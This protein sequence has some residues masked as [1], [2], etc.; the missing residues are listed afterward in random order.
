MDTLGIYLLVFFSYAGS[1]FSSANNHDQSD[2]EL[3][4]G[5][6]KVRVTFLYSARRMQPSWS[7]SLQLQSPPGWISCLLTKALDPMLWQ[8]QRRDTFPTLCHLIQSFQKTQRLFTLP[9]S[10]GQQE[11]TSAVSP[12]D[13]RSLA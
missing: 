12:N 6:N 13:V 10:A 9:P 8:P 1:L 2:L 3:R 11:S 7:L 5:S 4:Q